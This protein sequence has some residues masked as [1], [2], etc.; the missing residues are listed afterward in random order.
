MLV[1]EEFCQN[2]IRNAYTR[3]NYI[4]AVRQFLLWNEGRE[5]T[6]IRISSSDIHDYFDWFAVSIATKRLHSS[7]IRRFFDR[8]LDANILAANPAVSLRYGPYSAE[9]KA[10]AI[11]PNSVRKLFYSIDT[12][13]LIGLRDRAI[14]ALFMCTAARTGSIQQLRLDDLRWDG[15]QYVLRFSQRP[16]KSRE[17]PVQHE[18][19]EFLLEY[20]KA[21]GI[22]EGSLFR[23]APSRSAITLSNNSMSSVD[24]CRMIRRR[25]TD[26]GLP[27]N[28]SPSSFRAAAIS[29]LL[30]QNIPVE[31]VQF[32][33]GHADPRTTLCFDDRPR[34][35]KR[36]VVEM[37]PFKMDL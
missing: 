35:I 4:H 31:D 9:R 34:R 19:L 20:I 1:W 5:L 24:I 17:I 33:A 32:L 29:G 37:I 10:V 13:E 18:A 25:L 7:A 22:T 26:A 3:R 36:S 8:L 30:K 16:D 2:D 6:L 11:E 27:I 28:C 21:A 12:S 23:T 14:I 15:N